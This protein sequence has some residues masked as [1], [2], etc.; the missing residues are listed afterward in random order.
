MPVTELRAS[1]IIGVGSVSFEM[2]RFMS[3]QLPILAGPRWVHSRCQP[4]S[5]RN[6]LD[7]L[8]G[9]LEKPAEEARIYEIGGTDALRYSETMQVSRRYRGLKRPFWVLPFIPV[10]LMAFAVD[11]LTP[12][13]YNLA[14]PCC[15]RR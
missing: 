3:E 15:W 6:V 10:S 13:D 9:A 1:L 5:I 14:Y 12:V 4:I 11:L 7:Y 8:I 2:I